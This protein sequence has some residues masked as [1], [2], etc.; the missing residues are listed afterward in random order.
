[1]AATLGLDPA[2]VKHR[3]FMTA[4]SSPPPPHA[5]E[6][7]LPPA[8]EGSEAVPASSPTKA[9]AAA[10]AQEDA[11]PPGYEVGERP[12]AAAG[13][14]PVAGA[15]GGS[16]DGSAAAAVGASGANAEMTTPLGTKFPVG[17]YTLPRVWAQL[18]RAS[19]Y[20][21]RAAAAAAWNR[22]HAWSKRALAV[23]PVRFDCSPANVAAAMSVYADGSV[24]V[25]H[26]GIEVSQQ[27]GKSL[28]AFLSL[29]TCMLSLPPPSHTHTRQSHIWRCLC[30][31]HTLLLSLTHNCMPSSQCS[32][33]PEHQGGPDC[34]CMG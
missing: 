2:A 22:E 1:M 7:A 33:G 26:G 30:P 16:D 28:F 11:P 15:P 32:D 8:R 18:L 19:D 27:S 25:T 6:G 4:P 3:N 20:E 12:C 23:T 31:V 24:L 29:V 34:L 5:G 13:A 14:A 10:T 17:S 9:A 21:E